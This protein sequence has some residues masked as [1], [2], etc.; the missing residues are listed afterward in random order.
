MSY[1]ANVLS[2]QLRIGW[3]NGILDSMTGPSKRFT[4][5]MFDELENENPLCFFNKIHLHNTT[6]LK[7]SIGDSL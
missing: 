6:V 7:G 3:L 4:M 5:F 2:N 1:H